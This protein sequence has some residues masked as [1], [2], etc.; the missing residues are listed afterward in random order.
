MTSRIALRRAS[1][2]ARSGTLRSRIAKEAQPF[3][4]P[5]TAADRALALVSGHP[6]ASGAAVAGMLALLGLRRIARWTMRV[7]P[8][9]ALL[10]R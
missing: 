10:R 7:L 9:Y 5:L 3:M 2:V 8:F 1:L 4:R 6:L